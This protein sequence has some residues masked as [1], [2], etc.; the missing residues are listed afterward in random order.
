LLE[1]FLKAEHKTE[2]FVAGAFFIIMLIMT[3]INVFSRYFLSKSF[4]FAEEISYLGFAWST[5]IGMGNCFRTRSLV[6][7][8]VFVNHMPKGLQKAAAVAAD[9]ILLI[10]NIGLLY[11]STKITVSGWTRRSTNLGIPYTFYYLP[12]LIVCFIMLLTT[13][14]FL[15]QHIKKSGKGKEEAL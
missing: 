2:L 10:T 6:A 12:V 1:K 7:I 3:S 15:V 4:A 13:I 5:F 8:D 11:L 9:V 14:S